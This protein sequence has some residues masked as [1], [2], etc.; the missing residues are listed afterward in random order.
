M[1]EDAPPD[2]C[3]PPMAPA[4]RPAGA[5]ASGPA[6]APTTR[7]ADFVQSS[8]RVQGLFSAEREADLR[9]AIADIPTLH[10]VS[11]DFD[12]ALVTF[13]YDPKAAF[14]THKPDKAAERLDQLLRQAS[15]ATFNLRPTSTPREKLQRVEIVARALDCKACALAAH[16]MLMKIDGVEQ[17]LVSFKEGKITAQFDPAKTSRQQMETVLKEKGVTVGEK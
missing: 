12:V 7:P 10:V 16:E 13:A 17:A 15:N 1:E 14:P 11:I 6:T 8:H 4:T 3:A 5:S 2:E 9:A